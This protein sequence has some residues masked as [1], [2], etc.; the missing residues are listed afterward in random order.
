MSLGA[1]TVN[2]TARASGRQPDGNPTWTEA[3]DGVTV[4][5]DWPWPAAVWRR[6][7]R[8][9]LTSLIRLARCRAW[10]TARADATG[11]RVGRRCILM[12]L[13]SMRAAAAGDLPY[14]GGLGR[15]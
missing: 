7:L 2:Y 4:A 8:E 14:V 13:S 15:L 5:E 11:L 10:L 6:E 9:R 12:D 3:L 1:D